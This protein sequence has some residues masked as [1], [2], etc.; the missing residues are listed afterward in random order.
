MGWTS[1]LHSHHSQPQARAAFVMLMLPAPYRSL[2]LEDPRVKRHVKPFRSA[3]PVLR[4]M[5]EGKS[6]TAGPAV[7]SGPAPNLSPPCHCLQ[8]PESQ[9]SPRLTFK[10][11][12]VNHILGLSDRP[13]SVSAPADDSH[14]ASPRLRAGG[15]RAQRPV[16]WACVRSY[17]S[18]P[19]G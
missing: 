9:Y 19:G 17:R 10:R 8:S 12:L 4:L 13:Q 1:S 18:S 11:R 3:E 16:S 15:A 2:L 5:S 14:C 6:L 7:P